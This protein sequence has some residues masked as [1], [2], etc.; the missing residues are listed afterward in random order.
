MKKSRGFYFEQMLQMSRMDIYALAKQRHVF[1]KLTAGRETRHGHP[2]LAFALH[3]QKCYC[4]PHA[5]GANDSSKNVF[6]KFYLT[7]VR[8][9]V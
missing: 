1:S 7:Y 9:S 8:A 4:F 3:A 5:R 6:A 2:T